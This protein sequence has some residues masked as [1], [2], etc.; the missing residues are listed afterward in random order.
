MTSNTSKDSSKARPSSKTGPIQEAVA[1]IGST[2]AEAV[3]KAQRQ[4][5]EAVS[6]AWA[7]YG[8]ASRGVRAEAFK[9]WIESYHRYLDAVAK[10]PA[11]PDDKAVQAVRSAWIDHV[12]ACTPAEEA[13]HW[14]SEP[15]RTF[16]EAVGE[17][18]MV[19][20][21]TVTSANEA[22]SSSLGEVLGEGGLIGLDDVSAQVVASQVI[23]QS[24]AVAAGR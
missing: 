15:E 16:A 3:G 17:A 5:E 12:R 9:A 19:Y 14:A 23:A 7:D 6:K 13:P 24:M 20:G 4:W 2:Y 18:G 21:E 8:E 11:E 10:L 22:Y 1:K